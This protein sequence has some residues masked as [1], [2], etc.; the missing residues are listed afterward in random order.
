MK[1]V[2]K[3]SAARAIYLAFTASTYTEFH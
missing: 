1:N 2:C 3:K